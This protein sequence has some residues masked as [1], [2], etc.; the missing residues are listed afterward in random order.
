M[1]LNLSD[2]LVGA[3]EQCRRKFETSRLCSSQVGDEVKPGWQF[4]GKFSRLATF[5]NAV[6][7]IRSASIQSENVR[8][9]SYQ[10]ACLTVFFGSNG[11]QIVLKRKLSDGAKIGSK[12]SILYNTRQLR[13]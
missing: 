3:G 2:H 9:V 7:E 6:H 13:G 4:Y 1:Q 8:P 5:E 12:L 11:R 10:A